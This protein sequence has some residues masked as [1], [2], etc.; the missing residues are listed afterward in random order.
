MNDKIFYSS[1]LFSLYMLAILAYAKMTN[2]NTLR[3]LFIFF[4]IIALSSGL[5]K[6]WGKNG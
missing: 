6:V 3:S 4:M 2:D 5:N 1:S